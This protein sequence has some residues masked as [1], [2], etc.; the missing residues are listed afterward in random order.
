ML[1][2]ACMA[3]AHDED[4]QEEMT[5]GGIADEKQ[6]DCGLA[7]AARD[8]G[9]NPHACNDAAVQPSHVR[10]RDGP[11]VRSHVIDRAG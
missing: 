1:L 8:A 5:C 11:H 10:P 6:Q 3:R 2:A 4:G 9:A 7:L